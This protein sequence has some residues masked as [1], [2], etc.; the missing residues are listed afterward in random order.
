MRLSISACLIFTFSLCGNGQVALLAYASPNGGDEADRQKLTAN[1]QASLSRAGFEV[2]AYSAGNSAD[3]IIAFSLEVY[4]K[5]WR[6]E[7]MVSTDSTGAITRAFTTLSHH[8]TAFVSQVDPSTGEVSR[9]RSRILRN[10]LSEDF[11]THPMVTT[12]ATPSPGSRSYGTVTVTLPAELLSTAPTLTTEDERKAWVANVLDPG[13]KV[14]QDSMQANAI[15]QLTALVQTVLGPWAV[16]HGATYSSWNRAVRTDYVRSWDG[17]IPGDDL[18]ALV[19]QEYEGI[20][21][22][23]QLQQYTFSGATNT[24]SLRLPRIWTPLRLG[25]LALEEDNSSIGEREVILTAEPVHYYRSSVDVEGSTVAFSASPWLPLYDP[26]RLLQDCAASEYV[27]L[28]FP[29]LD[30]V[31]GIASAEDHPQLSLVYKDRKFELTDLQSGQTHT[32]LFGKS[33]QDRILLEILSRIEGG[34]DIVQA[35]TKKGLL[36]KGVLV[37]ALPLD[38][39]G[40]SGYDVGLA[41]GQSTT[42]AVINVSAAIPQ[43]NV[44]SFRVFEG[45]DALYEAYEDERELILLSRIR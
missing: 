39:T 6:K 20:E 17:L 1:L 11:K 13:I 26:G 14:I 43:S 25:E 24:D 18:V 19:V 23:I 3:T 41:G 5:L 32:L 42:I 7:I 15:V 16:P 30:E 27:E 4:S 10:L 8:A 22:P 33:N 29:V 37:S 12:V 35:K 34:V 21:L 31:L 2:G 36:K 44:Y 28:H 45:E 9:H 40:N 38:N